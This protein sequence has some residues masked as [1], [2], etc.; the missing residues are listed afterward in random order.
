VKNLQALCTR[1]TSVDGGKINP[2]PDPHSNYDGDGVVLV[3]VVSFRF[4]PNAANPINKV[5][6]GR[7]V[8]E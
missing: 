2:N 1:W 3:V 5:G 8:Y 6:Q 4:F 7:V